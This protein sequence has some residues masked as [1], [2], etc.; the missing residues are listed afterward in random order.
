MTQKIR[1]TP[2]ADQTLLLKILETHEL[3][4]DT[5]KVA[6]AWPGEEAARPT[7]RAIKE[8]I[9]KIKELNKTAA[10]ASSNAT[11][12]PSSGPKLPASKVVKNSTPAKR[13]RKK[14]NVDPPAKTE[15]PTKSEPPVKSEVDTKTRIVV[16]DDSHV[17]AEDSSEDEQK[18]PP[19]HD[20]AEEPKTPEELDDWLN[21]N[22]DA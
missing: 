9:A 8:R 6:A 22:I 18:V 3:S 15:P 7:P 10:C 11:D 21:L 1:W 20:V 5:N 12:S 4:V 13:G 16:E 19:V 2:S 17:K 14:K